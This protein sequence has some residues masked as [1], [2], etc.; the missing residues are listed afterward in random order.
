MGLDELHPIPFLLILSLIRQVPRCKIRSTSDV[1]KLRIVHCVSLIRREVVV[2][3]TAGVIPHDRHTLQVERLLVAAAD[4][5]IPSTIIGV[6]AEVMLRHIRLEPLANLRMR[7]RI[8]VHQIATVCAAT[9]H[10]EVQIALHVLHI[11]IDI[12]E[13]ARAEQSELLAIP[14]CEHD[15][16]LRCCTTRHE[17]LHNL[18][19][20]SHARRIVVGAIVY[21]T[22]VRDK[23]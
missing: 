16:A 21:L 17:S 2:G 19:H 4:R 14:E 23:K 8:E 10:I 15:S 7:S 20:G 12:G 3:L 5:G 18:Q 22:S 1:C 9:H 13:V 11:L 6:E